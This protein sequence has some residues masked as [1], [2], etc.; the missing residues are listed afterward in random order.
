M[1]ILPIVG[2]KYG[3]PY[4]NFFFYYT[5]LDLSQEVLH[6]WR[7][8]LSPMNLNSPTEEKYLR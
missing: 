6:S 7:R 8:N 3:K 1:F 4:K 5:E 2:L